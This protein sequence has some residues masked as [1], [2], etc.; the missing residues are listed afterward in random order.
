[1]FVPWGILVGKF[2][3]AYPW[4]YG[5]SGYP[6]PCP[7]YNATVLRLQTAPRHTR[8]A[9]MALLVRVI[10]LEFDKDMAKSPSIGAGVKGTDTYKIE[11][12]YPTHIR[13]ILILVP[14]G[15]Q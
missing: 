10:L 1:M 5:P 2:S 11:L 12:Y 6:G 3:L 13:E 4:P 9:N 15:I 14:Q 8:Y 7:K